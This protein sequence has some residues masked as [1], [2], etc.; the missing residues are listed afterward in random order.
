MDL[1]VFFNLLQLIGGI[2]LSVGY[3]PQIAKTIRTKSVE[4][5]STAYYFNI[6]IGVGCMEAYAIYSALNGV[7]LM[8]LVTNTIA[9][10]LGGTM[11]FLTIRYRK[12]AKING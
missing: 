6:F 9:W 3:I 12:R 2:I 1:G 7:A 11:L 10:V 4:D 8:F 5:L